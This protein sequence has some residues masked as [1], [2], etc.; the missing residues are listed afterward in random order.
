MRI[1]VEYSCDQITQGGTLR[2]V[3][4]QDTT[5][6]T[7]QRYLYTLDQKPECWLPQLL[8]SDE[9]N[10]PWLLRVVVP[11]D[12]MVICSGLQTQRVKDAKDALHVYEVDQAVPSQIG[13]L[14]CKFPLITTLKNSKPKNGVFGC[15]LNA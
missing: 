13:M 9:Q 6:Q 11:S 2:Y 8:G 3:P 5:S 1:L 14:C 15:F 10:S 12:Y 7:M 4:Y